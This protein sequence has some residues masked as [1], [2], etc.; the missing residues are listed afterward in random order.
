MRTVEIVNKYSTANAVTHGGTFHAD[1]VLATVMLSYIKGALK[2]YR[3]FKVDWDNVPEDAI[4]YDVGGKDFDHHM[5]GGQGKHPG[6]DID[7]ASAGLVW[8]TYGEEILRQFHCPENLISDVKVAVEHSLILG[9]DAIDNG[10]DAEQSQGTYLAFVVRGCNPT[11][12]SEKTSDQGFLQATTL[13]DDIF[14]NVV[15]SC[16]ATG[17]AKDKVNQSLD[18]RKESE[19][20]VLDRFVPWQAWVVN[21]P[22][23]KEVLYVV[24][25][26]SRGGYAVQAVP[27]ALG[28]FENRKPFPE[29]W[30]G[31]PEI[32]GVDGVRFI[33][34]AGFFAACDSLEAALALAEKAVRV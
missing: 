30:R 10:E 12:D 18:S 33:H 34:N 5:P 19:I 28:S 16:I 21:N 13:V 2:V 9:V 32:S 20:L 23:G 8:R 7:Y 6:T 11:W 26:D 14:S 17:K 3:T 31:H 22:K 15:R 24:F 4:V 25:P 27:K 29:A 1:D